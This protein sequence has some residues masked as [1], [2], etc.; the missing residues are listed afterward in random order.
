MTVVAVDGPAASG[1]GTISRR[2]ATRLNYAYLDT[3]L[4]YRAAASRLVQKSLDPNNAAMC[5]AAASTLCSQD[6]E[7]E[8]LRTEKIGKTASIVAAHQSVRDSLLKYQ[9]EFAA[10]PP[11]GKAGAVLDGRDIGTVVFP[12]AHAKLFIT[13]SPQTRAK[14]RFYEL[15]K[16]N[17]RITYDAILADIRA[18]DARDMKRIAAPLTKAEDAVLLDTTE[19]GKESACEAAFALVMK[20]L[21][22]ASKPPSPL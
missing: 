21:E 17:N 3:G 11:D 9:R 22:L 13:A 1:K 14:R 2:L 20:Q 6:L 7:R 18:R 16:F 12:N 8:D 10:F 19:M 15:S 4:L 5:T